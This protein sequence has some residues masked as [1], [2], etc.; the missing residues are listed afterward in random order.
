M[1]LERVDFDLPALAEK[2][3]NLYLAVEDGAPRYVAGDPLRLGQIVTNLVGN[4]VK[5]TDFG[6]ITV[7]LSAAPPGVKPIPAS[8]SIAEARVC[9]IKI[10]VRDTGIGIPA[11]K[12]ALIFESFSQADS[13]VTRHYGGTGLG[14]S[15]CRTLAA[16]FGGS[17][18]VESTVG[19]GSVFSFT[20][21]FERGDPERVKP[22]SIDRPKPEESPFGKP[23]LAVLLV[24]DSQVNAKVALRWLSQEGHRVTHAESGEAA[25]HALSVRGYDV[26]LMDIEM[27]GMDG[28]E[29]ARRIR[30][31]AA[32]AKYRGLPIIAMSAH[33]GVEFREA[34]GAAGM[35]DYVAKPIDFFELSAA[36]AR[37]ARAAT[38]E[39]VAVGLPSLLAKE[40]AGGA[41]LIDPEPP[42]KRLGGDRELYDEILGLFADEAQERAASIAVALATDYR[43][44]LR[45]LAHGLRGSA[46]TIGADALAEVAAV[47]ET[48]TTESPTA[49]G[50]GT[51]KALSQAELEALVTKL[52]EI[53]NASAQRA[54]AILP[55]DYLVPILE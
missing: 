21:F 31:G 26:V 30:A 20:A 22:D 54:R 23:S 6:G 15:L 40:R 1:T 32:G 7:T 51:A 17:I 25:I 35:D 43:E 16:L 34:V 39:L 55:P 33:S 5:F 12:Q 45:R 38:R 14:L 50:K 10:S 36:L 49:D 44:A 11:D 2:K 37:V 48:G 27:G 41:T 28:F 42:L 53:L 47:L 13:S 19:E 9:G 29:A 18:G 4:A 24:E 52:L 46:K 8:D 3:L